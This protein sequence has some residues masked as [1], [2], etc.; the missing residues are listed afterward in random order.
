MV[1]RIPAWIERGPL[2]GLS[3]IEGELKAVNARMD[4]LK[5]SMEEADKRLTIR[6]EKLE[7][8]MAMEAR[9]SSI[10]MNLLEKRLDVAERLAVIEAKLRK[11]VKP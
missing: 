11:H 4:A 6:V 9:A 10:R 3:V 2:P 5:I 7:K 1:S 8:R